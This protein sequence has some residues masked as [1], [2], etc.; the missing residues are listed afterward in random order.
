M[1]FN[2]IAFMVS[3]ILFSNLVHA[4]TSL[5]SAAEKVTNSLG[6]V[7]KPPVCDTKPKKKI[8]D[9]I[10]SA[11]CKA[12]PVKSKD[13]NSFTIKEFSSID[14]LPSGL[15]KLAQA[16][17]LHTNAPIKVL[18]R[19]T[20]DMIFSPLGVIAFIVDP[21]VGNID[22][23]GFDMGNTHS[24]NLDVSKTTD[25]GITYSLNGSSSLFTIA[26]GRPEYLN[27]DGMK[28]IPIF[29][30]EQNILS[31]TVD[32]EKTALNQKDALLWKA[33]IGIQEL[34]SSNV[35]AWGASGT[36]EAFHK[37]FKAN[38]KQHQYVYNLNGK[39]VR[40]AE[41][42]DLGLGLSKMVAEEG[43]CQIRAQGMIEP[44]VFTDIKQ[45]KV[46]TKLYLDADLKKKNSLLSLKAGVDGT[47][48]H[49]GFELTPMMMLSYERKNWGVESTVAFPTGD[50]VNNVDYNWTKRPLNSIAIY[51]YI[52][53]KKKNK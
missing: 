18:I 6:K 34:N 26:D 48:H 28:T 24:M 46:V 45:S 7:G 44:V 33:G 20:N 9:E 21:K 39:G 10:L 27:E 4:Q 23:P 2:L 40:T 53:T 43:S 14:A 36:Q 50:L 11:T 12:P 30:T 22:S 8:N 38:G 42:L 29:F 31:F 17:H 52:G 13:T 15:K 35:N 1:N 49:D 19:E 37:A 3:A 47:V 41:F 51:R 32:N 16:S 25:Q 5:N